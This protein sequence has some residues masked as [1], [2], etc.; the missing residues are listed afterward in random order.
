MRFLLSSTQDKLI[1]RY[2][3]IHPPRICLRFAFHKVNCQKLKMVK[4][5]A[6]PV[7]IPAQGHGFL[8]S[9]TMVKGDSRILLCWKME[10]PILWAQKVNAD[11]FV[12]A[13]F[14]QQLVAR[15]CK[16]R[17]KRP[18]N[19]AIRSCLNVQRLFQLT[20]CISTISTNLRYPSPRATPA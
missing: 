11:D 9:L 1:Q 16:L 19:W 14:N 17:L 4:G 7:F 10:T 8:A 6:W 15:F 2:P 3:G 18:H 20:A 13:L 12:E 5:G